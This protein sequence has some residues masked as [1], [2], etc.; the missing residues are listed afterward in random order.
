MRRWGMWIIE[1]FC[2]EPGCK[3][4]YRYPS[5]RPEGGEG[6]EEHAR[7]GARSAGWH[8]DGELSWCPEHKPRATA[9]GTEAPDGD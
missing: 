2:Q 4:H 3:V 6:E 5:A 9:S 1:L 7:R 8:C